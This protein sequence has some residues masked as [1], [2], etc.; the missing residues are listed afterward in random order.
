MTIETTIDRSLCLYQMNLIFDVTWKPA[1]KKNYLRVQLS[2]LTV[3]VGVLLVF[4]DYVTGYVL[5]AAGV[6][7][8]I[9]FFSFLHHYNKRKNSFLKQVDAENDRYEINGK[10][11]IWEFDEDFLYYSDYKQEVKYKWLAFSGFRLIQDTLFLHLG[12]QDTLSYVI[13]K[14]EVSEEEW[15]FIITLVNK[16]LHHT[17]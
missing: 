7:L 12:D 1:L 6:Y 13:G 8:L 15:D 5:I 10:T 17:H 9:N 14:K 4:Y 3:V 2:L 11:C 16:K